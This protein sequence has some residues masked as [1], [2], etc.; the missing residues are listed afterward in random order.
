MNDLEVFDHRVQMFTAVTAAHLARCLAAAGMLD[1]DAR[2]SIA[3]HFRDVTE[4]AIRIGRPEALAWVEMMA[5]ILPP[6]QG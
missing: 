2:S 1:S 4:T 3:G 5:T 6:P